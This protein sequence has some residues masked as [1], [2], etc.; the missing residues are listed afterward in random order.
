MRKVIQI[1]KKMLYLIYQ[2]QTSGAIGQEM[3]KAQGC[4]H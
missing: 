2:M 3:L 1:L 4:E